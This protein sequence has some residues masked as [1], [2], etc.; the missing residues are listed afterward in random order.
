MP[1]AIPLAQEIV[2]QSPVASRIQVVAGN[3]FEDEL[4]LGDLYSLGRILHDWS[5]AKII[6]LLQRIHAR[7]PAGGAVLIAEKLL[8]DDKS[9]PRWAQMQNLN[10][11][12]CT[13]GKERTLGEYE[14]LLTQCG[15]VDVAGCR[16]SSPLDAVLAFKG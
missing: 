16:T 15:F 8:H 1:E 10:M 2:G 5:E 14:S 6:Q 3:F 11:L 7:L 13:E 9:G 4:P 12:T